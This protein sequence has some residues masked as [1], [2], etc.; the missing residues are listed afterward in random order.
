MWRRRST[1][2]RGYVPIPGRAYSGA[3]TLFNCQCHCDYPRGC[4]VDNEA[5]AQ[6]TRV[7]SPAARSREV[8]IQKSGQGRGFTYK[9]S[10]NRSASGDDVVQPVSWQDCRKIDSRVWTQS[11][12]FS[13][14]FPCVE[15]V[16]SNVDDPW[17]SHRE[18]YLATTRVA[19]S[20]P[21]KWRTS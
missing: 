13:K 3:N 15:G 17:E 11:E 21:P 4:V 6:S 2:A 9:A 10:Q 19:H 16:S 20:W 12:S 8:P 7:A 1:A 14:F 5:N 18:F